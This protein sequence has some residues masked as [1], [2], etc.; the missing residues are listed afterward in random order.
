MVIWNGYIECGQFFCFL[1]PK[2]S[3]GVV[4]CNDSERVIFKLFVSGV[5]L[6]II[7]PS[8]ARSLFVGVELLENTAIPPTIITS[9]IPRITNLFNISN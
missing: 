5:L 8:E 9:I 2:R 7:S 3:Y 6:S 4:T 1:V